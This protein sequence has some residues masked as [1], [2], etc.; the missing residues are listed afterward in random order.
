MKKCY[1]LFG[2]AL[3]LSKKNNLGEI[4]NISKK[5]VSLLLALVMVFSLVACGTSNDKKDESAKESTVESKKEGEVTKVE[6][7]SV[8]FVPSRD[9]E[10]IMSATKPLEELLK[11]HLK[12]QGFEV[13]KIAISVGTTYEA[14]GEA[15]SA[16]TVDVGLIPGGTYVLYDDGAEVLLTATRKG[17]SNDSENAKDW[18]D[19]K[20]TKL[21]EEQVTYYRSIMIAGPSEKGQELAKK[22]NAGEELTW[23]DIKDAKWGVRG[24]SSSAGYIYPYLYLQDKF[25]KTITDLTSVVEMDN[26]NTSLAQLAT[27]QLDVV[28]AF[29]DAR[30]DNEDKWQSEYQGKKTIWEDT[31]VIGVTAPIYNDTVSVSKKSEKM[32]PELKEAIANAFIELAK[33]DEGQEVIKI[34]NHEGYEKA[35]SEDYDKER[36]AQEIMKELNQ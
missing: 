1:T 26:Y 7:L 32:T 6:E 20:P 24:I 25:G 17:L 3:K 9:P 12:D 21:N 31:N 28:V 2:N 11:K 35:K 36:K 19:N 5:L 22:V 18:N 30:M 29:A 13:D 8:Q 33:T 16:G 27:G 23:D 4:M 10:E 14:T 34:Y 15:L